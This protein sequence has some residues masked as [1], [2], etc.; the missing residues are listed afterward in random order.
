[1]LIVL[2]GTPVV[3]Y[4]FQELLWPV[5]KP[6]FQEGMG[7]SGIASWSH[8]VRIVFYGSFKTS[9]FIVAIWLT[10]KSNKNRM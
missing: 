10:Y 9:L 1:M 4:Q 7:V 6:E 3:Y 2:V 5:N 8:F